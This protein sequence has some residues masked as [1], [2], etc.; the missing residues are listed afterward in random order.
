MLGLAGTPTF[1]QFKRLI[2]GLDPHT[3]EQLTAK[4][5]EDRI[6]GW[7][8]T[9]SL[10]KGV[11]T[12]L[13]RGDSRI[14][15][16]FWEAANEA[17][18]DV[19][20][21]ATTRV[22]KGGKDD[23]RVTGNMVW[24]AVEH[25]ETR[26]AKEDGMPDWDRHIHFVVSNVTLDAVEGQWKAV[27]VRPIFDLRKYFSHRLRPADVGKAGRSRLRN[28]NQTQAR[29]ARRHEIPHLGHQGGTRP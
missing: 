26:P 27:K 5:I 10:P 12:A 23:D 7:D 11:T 19:E 4:L 14:Q 20:Q 16:L 6:P 18:D 9:A 15:A 22:R 28:R 17:M 1:E 25:P 24:F 29:R 13:E 2:H 3:G 8:F 21:Q